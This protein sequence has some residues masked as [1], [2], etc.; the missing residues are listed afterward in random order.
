MQITFILFY[1]NAAFISLQR[2][3]K[4]LRKKMGGAQANH[5]RFRVRDVMAYVEMTSPGDTTL[6]AGIISSHDFI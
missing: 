5:F 2:V 6:L 3:R 1:F 4:K